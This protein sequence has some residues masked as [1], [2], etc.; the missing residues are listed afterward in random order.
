VGSL[1]RAA[2]ADQPASHRVLIRF[3]SPEEVLLG[4]DDGLEPLPLEVLLARDLIQRARGHFA[5]D[6]SGAQDNVILIELPA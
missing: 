4:P 6:A 5:V 1:Y 3:H 2:Q